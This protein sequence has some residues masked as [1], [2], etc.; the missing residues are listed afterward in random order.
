VT[1]KARRRERWIGV[2]LAAVL[3]AICVGGATWATAMQLRNTAAAEA[4]AALEA[5]QGRRSAAVLF[6][7]LEGNVCRRRIIDNLTWLI[8]DAGYAACDEAVTW[9]AHSPEAGQ[10]LAGRLEQMRTSFRAADK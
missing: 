2:L 9:N 8:T 3:G 10:Q 4:L 5:E 6:V 7:P 1:Q